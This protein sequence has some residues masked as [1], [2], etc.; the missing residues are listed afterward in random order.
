MYRYISHIEIGAYFNVKGGFIAYI[1]FLF[2]YRAD[3]RIFAHFAHLAC[4]WYLANVKAWK[5]EK[6]FL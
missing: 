1:F 4:H 6:G 5:F 2:I 3:T